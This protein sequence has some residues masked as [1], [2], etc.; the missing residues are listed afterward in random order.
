MYQLFGNCLIGQSGGPTSAI[1]AS[2]CGVVEQ[3]LK[4][5]CI[6]NAYGAIN[7][8][9]GILKRQIFDIGSQL[10]SKDD[11]ELLKTTPAAYLGSCRYKLPAIHQDTETYKKIFD[12]FS[13]Y[14]IR[15]FFYIGGN[16]SMDTVAKLSQYAKKIAYP[17]YIIGIPKTIDNDLVGTDH[18]PGFGSAAKFVATTTLEITRDSCVYDVDS[19]TI[20][21]IMGRNSGWLTAATALARNE[22]NSSPDLIYLPEVPFSIDKF[23]ED[24]KLVKKHK[25]NVVV[26]ISEG[27]K[28]VFG[29]Y[30]CET[31]NQ[32]FTDAFGH[33]Y[34]GG[35][36][37]ILE[38]AVRNRLRCKVRSIELNILQ[39]C[40]IHMASKTDLEEAY[41]IGQQAVKSAENGYTGKMMI[42]KREPGPEYKV[43]IDSIDIHK[44]AN[45]EKKVPV[46]WINEQGND[47]TSELIDY[48]K[49]LIIGNVELKLRDGLPVYLVLDTTPF[50]PKKQEKVV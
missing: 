49:P 31:V 40:A 44:I 33:K 24:I 7:G 9:E 2:L 26:A 30:I 4:S 43:S 23:I 11:L 35:T 14:D 32:G 36:A 28:N 17:I 15:Y 47:I 6:Q 16:D 41:K 45:V 25:K 8:I 5:K 50:A 39:R 34:L 3:A 46:E 38:N 29:E 27:I 12:I 42:L 22:Y 20:I 21:E 48:I 37:K 10:K 1:N 13:Q 19:V 18:T